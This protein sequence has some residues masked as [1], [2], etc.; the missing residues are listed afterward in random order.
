M[1][2]HAV[3]RQHLHR[4]HV[5]AR[6]R[7]D[8]R[9]AIRLVHRVERLCGQHAAQITADQS[10]TFRRRQQEWCDTALWV[11]P[12]TRSYGITCVHIAP[13]F[14]EEFHHLNVSVEHS[15]VHRRGAR[16]YLTH[17][18]Q[19]HLIR[20]VRL[21]DVVADQIARQLLLVLARCEMQECGAIL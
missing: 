16:L 15:A 9:I 14:E 20:R 21:V 12:R 7:Q 3:L 19:H 2:R 18:H 4:V 13:Q 6:Q 11:T 8:Q 1:K 5:T 17:T 10:L